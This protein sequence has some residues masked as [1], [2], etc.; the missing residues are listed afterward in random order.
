[1]AR[2]AVLLLLL[3]AVAHGLRLVEE[4]DEHNTSLVGPPFLQNRVRGWVVVAQPTQE[5]ALVK[6]D[7]YKN[8]PVGLNIAFAFAGAATDKNYKNGYAF[9]DY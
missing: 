5:A 2:V 9:R 6:A 8:M 4:E 1:M 3:P 7:Q